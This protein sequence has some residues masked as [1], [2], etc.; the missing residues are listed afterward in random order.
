MLTPTSRMRW[1]GTRLASTDL[2]NLSRLPFIKHSINIIGFRDISII[3]ILS[4]FYLSPTLPC[5]ILAP[6]GLLAFVFFFVFG[7][8]RFCHAPTLTYAYT[9][10]RLIRSNPFSP[11]PP[12]LSHKLLLSL[13]LLPRRCLPPYVLL[14]S[15]PRV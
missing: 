8:T 3:V 1:C 13:A 15:R 2:M 6:P 11:V 14:V 4:M 5:F 10:I 7:I 12:P 9:Y